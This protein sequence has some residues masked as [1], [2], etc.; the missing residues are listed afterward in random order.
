MIGWRF[1]PSAWEPVEI[2]QFDEHRTSNIEH[3]TPN[4]V[5]ARV[6]AEAV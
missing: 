2:S 5:G 4:G 3:P 1:L 6:V